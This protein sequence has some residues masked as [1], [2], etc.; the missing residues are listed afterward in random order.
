MRARTWERAAATAVLVALALVHG[1]AA[2]LASEVDFDHE[3]VATAAE[4]MDDFTDAFAANDDV[5]AVT[6][7]NGK[8]FIKVLGSDSLHDWVNNMSFIKGSIA[9]LRC[10]VGGQVKLPEDKC[11]SWRSAGIGMRGFIESF[12]QL[13]FE[14]LRQM[15]KKCDLARDNVVVVGHSRGGA[16]AQ[17]AAAVLFLDE[18]VPSP[19]LALVTFGSPRVLESTLS[20]AVHDKFT[21]I[22]LI[23]EEDPVPSTP[24]AWLAYK[25]FGRMYCRDCGYPMERDE[26]KLA[27]NI[28]EVSDHYLVS[29][30][31]WLTSSLAKKE[32]RAA[33]AHQAETV[34]LIL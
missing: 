18:I 11:R 15:R 33:A 23:N 24:P 27:F 8:C 17:T 31:A 10:R 16:I 29:Y 25:H 21:Q 2:D 4:Q 7:A 20:D 5:M 32:A 14:M 28:F 19:R 34:A 6:R 13:R 3:L 9:G 30:Q 1:A 26:P 12:N 22:R